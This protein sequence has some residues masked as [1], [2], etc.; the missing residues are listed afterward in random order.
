MTQDMDSNSGFKP[1]RLSRSAIFQI[2]ILKIDPM[3]RL[4][5]FEQ[6]ERFELSGVRRAF[7]D[8]IV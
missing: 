5:R 3:S 4:Q 2:Q 7:I 8:Q 6:L 1:R